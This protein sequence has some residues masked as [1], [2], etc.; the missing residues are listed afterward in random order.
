MCIIRRK[1]RTARCCKWGKGL[2]RA[3]KQRGPCNYI[4]EKGEHGR[5]NLSERFFRTCIRHEPS[6]TNA[7]AHAHAQHVPQVWASNWGN[8]MSL[9]GNQQQSHSL[10]VHVYGMPSS[11]VAYVICDVVKREDVWKL[12]PRCTLSFQ[13]TVDNALKSHFTCTFTIKLNRYRDK[14]ICEL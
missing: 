14:S 3:Q 4:A 9:L 7:Y 10:L 11:H 6:C 8:G 12:W 5:Q 13:S 1:A 2:A